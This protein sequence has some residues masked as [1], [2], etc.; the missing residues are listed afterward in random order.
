MPA[1]ARAFTVRHIQLLRALFAAVAALMITFSSDHSAAV[2][3]SVF[4]G[5]AITTA[6]V[7]AI[8]AWL[9]AP[10]GRRWPLVLLA[11]VSVGAG[12]TAGIPAWRND[13]VFFAVVVSWALLSGLIELIAGIRGRREDDPLSRDAILIGALGILLGV[14]LLLIPSG[15]AVEYTVEDAGTFLLTGI[16][17]G[18]GIF[19][20][21]AALTAVFLGIAGFTPSRAT[22][23]Q[24]DAAPATGSAA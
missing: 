7:L 18:V 5:F 8:G 23:T 9:A 19:G 12:M 1:P 10:A 17:L 15:F 14:A 11:A 2:G 3:L 20:G 16:I 13:D 6:F 4:S 22:G 24:A 21:Y